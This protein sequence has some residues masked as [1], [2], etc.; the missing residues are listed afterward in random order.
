M[1]LGK[2]ER[3]HYIG[4]ND[5]LREEEKRKQLEEKEHA[6]IS[7]I[8][9]A[10]KAEATTGFAAFHGKKAGRMV[11]V[12]PVNLP[13]TR[14]FVE[15]IILECRNKHITR[16]DLLA[17][18]FEMG[19]FPNIL[20]DARAKGIDIA[21]KYIPA[22]VFDK[23]AI[24]K[25]QVVFH[26]VAA[27]EVKPHVKKNSIAIELTDFS[28]YHSQDSIASAEESLKNGGSKIVIERGQIVKVAKDKSGIVTREV[29]TRHWTDWIDYWAVD[30]DFE[31]KREIVR[32]KNEETGEFDEVWTVIMFL[33]RMAVV[34][35]QERQDFGA[36]Q[37]LPRITS[38]SLQG[39]GEGGGYLRQ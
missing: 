12:G 22:E 28:V 11:V 38:R 25:N 39:G 7:L 1:N 34:P 35:Y 20:E 13:V 29:L 5:D 6:F 4:L 27:I 31:S 10:Y 30:F 23:R 16:V 36:D 14:L 26:D 21:P 3:Q 33:K 9:R 37:R 19:L 24:E 15:E 8:L 32:V 2:Y 18:D 17:F